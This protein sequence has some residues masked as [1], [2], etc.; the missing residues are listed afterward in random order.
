MEPGNGVR[1]VLTTEI[2]DSLKAEMA[3]HFAQMEQRLHQSLLGAITSQ[4]ARVD[5]EAPLESNEISAFSVEKVRAPTNMLRTTREQ[6][7]KLTGL[8]DEDMTQLQVR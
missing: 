4:G 8:T 1:A 3:R 7:M 6:V 5:S 2:L